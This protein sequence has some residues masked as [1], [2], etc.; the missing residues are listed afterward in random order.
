MP[1]SGSIDLLCAA[2]ATYTMPL[3]VML[4]SVVSTLKT[5]R[6]VHIHIITSDIERTEQIRVERTVRLAGAGRS[7]LH[8]HWSS[9]QLSEFGSFFSKGHLDYMSPDTYSRL[10][11]PQVLPEDCEQVI[12][13]DCD[14]VVLADL[15]D[16]SDAADPR[17][18]L[19]AVSN[20]WFPYVSSKFDTTPVV[21]NFEE[22]GIPPTNRYFQC[23]VLVINLRRWRDRNVTERA[24][25][26]LS[27][28]RS[29]VQFHDQ[30][31]LNAILYDDWFRLDQRWNQVST[32]LQPDRWVAPAYSRADWRRA[33]NDPFIV[34]YDGQDK[35]WKVGFKRP[36]SS[37]FLKYLKK[38][39]YFRA[40]K[41]S[42]YAMLESVI[43]YRAYYS[44]WRS[45]IR[46]AA[47]MRGPRAA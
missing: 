22:L 45:K 34:H 41:V 36:R 15:A 33:K 20:V 24:F 42:P 9:V 44:L 10:L 1:R 26:Y 3:T 19:S 14:V 37:F 18:T 23:G 12:Y 16:L 43:G 47:M 29:E 8:I 2:N 46:I 35:P 4:T 5:G 7:P 11:A 21:F 32:A 27:K 6:P 38:T 30:G 28:H 39:P 40:V 31:A 17:F 13:L 25:S